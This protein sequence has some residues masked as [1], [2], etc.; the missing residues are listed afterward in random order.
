MRFLG[1]IYR[2]L[3]L[4]SGDKIV[5]TERNFFAAH[6]SL[7]TA[8]ARGSASSSVRHSLRRSGDGDQRTHRRLDRSCAPDP[9][10]TWLPRC[11]I[12]STRRTELK[13][14]LDEITF[15][16][17]H[18]ANN[19]QPD[20]EHVL[21]SA[22][23]IDTFA[24][25]RTSRTIEARATTSSRPVAADRS[26]A[27]AGKTSLGTADGVAPAR[28]NDAELRRKAYMAWMNSDAAPNELTRPADD[29]RAASAAFR[30]PLGALSAALDWRLRSNNNE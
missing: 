9:P 1:L 29:P 7:R 26:S 22:D 19:N 3:R 15:A 24:I 2:G 23:R 5:T 28:S 16:V 4:S 20:R 8:A 12:R 21:L 10:R 25:E 30:A 6:V 17:V 11:D 27:R 13:L 18:A 14:P